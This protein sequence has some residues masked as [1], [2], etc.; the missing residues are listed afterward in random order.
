MWINVE[1]RMPTVEV[2]G[3]QE[4]KVK[5]RVGSINPQVIERVVLAKKHKDGC[6][7][8]VGDWEKVTHWYEEK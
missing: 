8:L 7:F 3:I 5:L 6:R 2:K 4:F 1:S